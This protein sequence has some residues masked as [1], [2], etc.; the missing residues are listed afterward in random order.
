MLVSYTA[1][2]KIP[3][4]INFKGRKIYFDSRFQKF[5]SMVSGLVVWACDEVVSH[6]GKEREAEGGCSC[7]AAGEQSKG[8]SWGPSIPFRGTP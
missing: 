1:L 7:L 6:G 5:L 3:E 8:R 2:C 4:F